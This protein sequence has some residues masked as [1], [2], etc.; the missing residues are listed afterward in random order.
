MLRGIGQDDPPLPRRI[1]YV[2]TEPRSGIR[3]DFEPLADVGLPDGLSMCFLTEV[4][5]EK[6]RII[7]LDGGSSNCREDASWLPLEPTRIYTGA[8]DQKAI[9]DAVSLY[10]LG[11]VDMAQ[12]MSISSEV[13]E[14]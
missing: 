14:D 13:G 9:E 12:Q 6:S 7:G 3:A 5:D 8:I 10:V 11:S 1:V 4:L 2:V